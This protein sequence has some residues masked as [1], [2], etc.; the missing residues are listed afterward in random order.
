MDMNWL[1]SVL[2]LNYLDSLSSVFQ[3]EEQRN[4]V[5]A[6]RGEFPGCDHLGMNSDFSSSECL[7]DVLPLAVVFLLSC[8]S[9]YL[10]FFQQS[11]SF[12]WHFPWRKHLQWSFVGDGRARH[13]CFFFHSLVQRNTFSLLNWEIIGSELTLQWGLKGSFHSRGL[14]DASPFRP[15]RLSLQGFHSPG[16]PDWHKK[17]SKILK[18]CQTWTQSD[19]IAF[20]C[21]SFLYPRD[22]VLYPRHESL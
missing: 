19:N 18:Q 20:L 4:T 1:A 2:C 17:I 13:R 7:L 11:Y 22:L 12:K 14:S 6:L 10:L 15:G 21:W 16:A 9:V 3:R 8:L 5:A